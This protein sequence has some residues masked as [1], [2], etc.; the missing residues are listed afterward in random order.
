MCGNTAV[1]GMKSEG[2][3]GN[4]FIK[5]GS[6]STAVTVEHKFNKPI[7][8]VVHTK[9]C[10]FT[11][12]ECVAIACVFFLQSDTIDSIVYNCPASPFKALCLSR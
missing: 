2:Y 3:R 1:M 6:G 10:L 12:L 9:P 8:F 4:G 5:C 7:K 11:S